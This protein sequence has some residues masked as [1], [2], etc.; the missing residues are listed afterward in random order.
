MNETL[1]F[2]NGHYKC[3]SCKIKSK[4]NTIQK[5]FT[6]SKICQKTAHENAKELAYKV[7]LDLQQYNGKKEEEEEEEEE[8]KEEKEK[9]EEACVKKIYFTGIKIMD[10]PK[11]RIC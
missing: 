11:F 3:I 5:P 1:C 8:E 10:I 7:E 6:L 9:K 2:C 4:I